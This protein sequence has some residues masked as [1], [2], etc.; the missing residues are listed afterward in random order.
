[1]DD[2]TCMVNMAKFFLDFTAKESCGKCVH[3]RLGTRRMLEILTRITEGKGKAGDIELLEELC[4]AVKD[5]ALCGL[6][7]TAPNPVLTTIRYFRNEYEAHISDKTCP[8]KECTELLT[9]T[10][11]P[12]KCIG[13]TACARS[14]P[15]QTIKGE[16]KQP[17][18]ILQEN[19]I[20]C[21]TCY[22]KCKFGAISVN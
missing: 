6:G 9:Y 4:S 19:C 14:C 21:G 8:A 22:T 7:Q 3:C 13:C 17:H 12:D 10:I 5:G 11:D 1:M 15:T 2:S 18:T 20:K 16:V